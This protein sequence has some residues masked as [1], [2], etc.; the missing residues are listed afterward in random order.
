[1]K[2][3]D[4][5]VL[6]D[7]TNFGAMGMMPAHDKFEP[8]DVVRF[9]NKPECIG[10]VTGRCQREVDYE[11]MGADEVPADSFVGKQKIMLDFYT[12]VWNTGTVKTAGEHMVWQLER[13]TL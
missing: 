2:A 6:F 4:N 12:I 3:P 11:G 8:G 13:V 10:L 7:S 5:S 1:M 9:K